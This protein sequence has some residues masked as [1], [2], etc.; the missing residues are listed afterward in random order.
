MKITTNADSA[1]SGCTASML[2][3]PQQVLP[4]VWRAA[5]ATLIHLAE[6][7]QSM[8]MSWSFRVGRKTPTKHRTRKT[9]QSD[10][11][12]PVTLQC[13]FAPRVNYFEIDGR[14]TTSSYAAVRWRYVPA[15]TASDG[16]DSARFGKPLAICSTLHS[17]DDPA[18]MRG[19]R[20]GV[21]KSRPSITVHWS[22][23]PSIHKRN[24]QRV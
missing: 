8:H 17:L 21:L 3:F 7:V 18:D 12:I 1:S 13:P 10:S 11:D 5:L 2:Q 23:Q 15:L 20:H 9:T 4:T 6:V 24:N 14:Y 19:R 16:F 22:Q